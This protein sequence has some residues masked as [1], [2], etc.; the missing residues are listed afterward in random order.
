MA[1][2]RSFAAQMRAFANDIPKQVHA[3]KVAAMQE[4][5][6]T[7]VP[8]TPVKSGKARSNYIVSAGSPDHSTIR[9]VRDPSGT[10]SLQGAAAVLRGTKP[11]DSLYMT[12]NLPYMDELNN[13]SSKQAP[14]G[15]IQSSVMAA[16]QLIARQVIRFKGG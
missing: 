14:A 15:F 7:V 1:P 10:A 8:A 13:G 3:I 5:V 6:N 11:G 9:E 12:N 16:E 4:I 2:P